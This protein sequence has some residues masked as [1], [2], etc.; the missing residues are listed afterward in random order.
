MR[1]E[2]KSHVLSKLFFSLEKF[3]LSVDF[4]LA[5]KIGPLSAH[6]QK[7]IRMAFYWRADSDPW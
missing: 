1:I 4:Q 6:H 5:R 2:S 3:G 7:A